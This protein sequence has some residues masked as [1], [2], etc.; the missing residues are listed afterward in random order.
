MSDFKM[1]SEIIKAENLMY[2][3]FYAEIKSFSKDGF[4][5]FLGNLVDQYGADNNMNSEETCEMLETLSTI[6]KEIHAEL[7]SAVPMYEQKGGK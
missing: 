4:L 6:Q 3:D 2:S 7:G 5:M 1:M